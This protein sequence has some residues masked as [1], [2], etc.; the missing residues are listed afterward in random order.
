MEKSLLIKKLLYVIIVSLVGVIAILTVP[1]MFKKTA[2]NGVVYIGYE[3]LREKLEGEESF[4]LIISREGCPD[5]RVLK[6]DIENNNKNSKYK[7]YIFEYEIGHGENVGTELESIFPEFVLVPYV[8]FVRDGD[9]IKYDGQIN[10]SGI[11]EWLDTIN[12]FTD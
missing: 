8:C 4:L 2:S 11:N 12:T 9:V 5:C 10:S 1:Y 7:Y 3:E 6:E